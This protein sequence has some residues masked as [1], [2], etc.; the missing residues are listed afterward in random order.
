MARAIGPLL[1]RPRLRKDIID[2]LAQ[3]RPFLELQ[4]FFR[5]GHGQF[6]LLRDAPMLSPCVGTRPIRRSHL[7]NYIFS[8]DTVRRRLA[9]AGLSGAL[10]GVPRASGHGQ[11]GLLNYKN[12]FSSQNAVRRRPVGAGL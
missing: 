3:K 12:S 2:Y 10:S 4:N 8:Q 7:K 9:G 6:G 1:L 11:F 5:S